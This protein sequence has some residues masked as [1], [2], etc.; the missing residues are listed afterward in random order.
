[1]F[2]CAGAFDGMA[3]IVGARLGRSPIGFGAD[4]RVCDRAGLLD[5]VAPEDLVR[6]GLLPELVGRLP[7]VAVFDRLSV[8]DLVRVLTEPRNSL[9]R[10]FQ[11]L[12]AMDGVAL[13][14]TP[15]ALAAIA[16]RAVDLGSGARGL[17]TVL[18][19]LMLDYMFEAPSLG[20]GTRIVIDERAFGDDPPRPF[21]LVA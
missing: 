17:R 21:D 7:V 19:A 18:E 6:F 11:H 4:R 20:P 1:L 10:Q 13:E 12:L 9:V 5:A 2:V 8:D 14:F 3:E 16:R 15:G